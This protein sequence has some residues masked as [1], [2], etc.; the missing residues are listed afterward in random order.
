MRS[1]VQKGAAVIMDNN[2]CD[3]Y[4]CRR[5]RISGVLDGGRSGATLFDRCLFKRLDG[6]LAFGWLRLHRRTREPDPVSTG[7]GI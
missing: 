3:L 4:T 2:H 1:A 6:V 5:H 7:V